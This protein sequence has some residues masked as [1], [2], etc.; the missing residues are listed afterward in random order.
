MIRNNLKIEKIPIYFIIFFKKCYYISIE[1]SALKKK[2]S[3]KLFVLN[4][5]KNKIIEIIKIKICA[6]VDRFEIY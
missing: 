1:I 4:K 3:K 5:L 2:V 6:L